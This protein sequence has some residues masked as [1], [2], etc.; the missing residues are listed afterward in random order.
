MGKK[1]IALVDIDTKREIEM[2]QGGVG[3]F[4]GNKFIA[5]LMNELI[6]F[7]LE[8]ER[9]PEEMAQFIIE[10]MNYEFES[11]IE[12]IDGDAVIESVRN[13]IREKIRAQLKIS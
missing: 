5:G 3:V 6:E 13:D 2:F 11:M 1:K 9:T 12:A 7:Y 4:E 8:A 10:R